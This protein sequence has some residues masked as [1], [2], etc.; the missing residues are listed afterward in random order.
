[1]LREG[2]FAVE[3][4]EDGSRSWHQSLPFTDRHGLGIGLPLAVE[5]AASVRRAR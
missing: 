1:V 3:R 2:V 5:A 4:T